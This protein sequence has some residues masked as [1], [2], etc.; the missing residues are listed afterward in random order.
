MKLTIH[1]A[2]DQLGHGEIYFGVGEEGYQRAMDFL[3]KH[4]EWRGG[5]RYEYF[6]GDE[7]ILVF[8][9]MNIDEFHRLMKY[10]EGNPEL[11]DEWEYLGGI[12][13]GEFKLE[14]CMNEYCRYFN[15][16]RLG[17]ENENYLDDGTPY[18][19]DT[20]ED[21]FAYHPRRTYVKFAENIEKQIVEMLNAHPD[22]IP[23]AL[24]RT[25]PERWYPGEK[26]NWKKDITRIG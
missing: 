14:L 11:K 26:I 18:G 6:G 22:M 19:T 9:D 13:F 4:Q 23:Y 24:K 12:F 21:F 25:P 2:H 15:L 16:F 17:I 7:E 5:E 10:P 8:W 20:A 1:S 3:N